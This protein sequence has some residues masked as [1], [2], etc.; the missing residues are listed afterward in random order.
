MKLEVKDIEKEKY[1]STSKITT[2]LGICKVIKVITVSIMIFLLLG[3]MMDIIDCN[4]DMSVWN[5]LFIF[6][7]II[8]V[9]YLFVN[10]IYK[11][12]QNANLYVNN[13]REDVDGYVKILDLAFYVGQN[14][15]V[16]INNFSR[17]LKKRYIVNCTLEKKNGI[18]YI[19]LNNSILKQAMKENNEINEFIL[20]DI[21]DF[22]TLK[23]Y[24][25][26]NCGNSLKIK[27]VTNVVCEY[28]RSKYILDDVK[29]YNEVNIKT[30]SKESYVNYTKMAIGLIVAIPLVMFFAVLLMGSVGAMLENIEEISKQPTMIIVFITF[31]VLSICMLLK[32][33]KRIGNF[34]TLS[35]YDLY[36]KYHPTG[37]VKIEDFATRFNISEQKAIEKIIMFIQ[38]NYLKNCRLERFNNVNYLVLNKTIKQSINEDSRYKEII[39]KDIEDYNMIQEYPCPTCGATINIKNKENVVCD[40]CRTRLHFKR[41]VDNKKKTIKKA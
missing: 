16:V 12:V 10:K 26:P 13:F 11:F 19:I 36:F 37:I 7:C 3:L 28:C 25:C 6:L 15:N 38:Q 35:S 33:S 9:V 39:L 18:N 2:I 22:N 17:L 5:P 23:N 1:K 27:D 14:E 20:D 31:I 29:R 4:L 21:K 24:K 8:F 34:A 32:N 30:D 40:Y 41:L